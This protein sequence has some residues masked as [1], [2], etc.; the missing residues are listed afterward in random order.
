MLVMIMHVIRT[1]LIAKINI[2]RITEGKMGHIE[3][4][5]WDGTRGGG[6]L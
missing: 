2:A 5:V 4:I 6:S 1:K 3:G